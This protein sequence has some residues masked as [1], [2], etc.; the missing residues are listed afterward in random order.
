[1]VLI[2]AWV[3]TSEKKKTKVAKKGKAVTKQAKVAAKK[4]PPLKATKSTDSIG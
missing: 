1:V 4:A 3:M 2:I